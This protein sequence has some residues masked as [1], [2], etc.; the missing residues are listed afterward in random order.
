LIGFVI[1]IISRSYGKIQ[2]KE[3]M[4]IYRWVER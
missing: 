1:T 3:A 4:G 2:F